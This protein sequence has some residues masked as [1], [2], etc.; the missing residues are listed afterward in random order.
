[1]RF[2]W[3]P[4][5]Q[6]FPEHFEPKGDEFNQNKSMEDRLYERSRDSFAACVGVELRTVSKW[7]SRGYVNVWWADRI[8][9]NNGLHPSSIWP[10]EWLDHMN[11]VLKTEEKEREQTRL[12][13]I[14]YRK[15]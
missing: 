2:P 15:P 9:V 10:E 12:R 14:K 7:Q 11:E 1:M 6:A 5:E 4:V 3:A 8:A 13:T